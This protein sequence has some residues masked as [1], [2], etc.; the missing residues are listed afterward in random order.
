MGV[1]LCVVLVQTSPPLEC[2]T[3]RV[4]GNEEGLR[5]I[6]GFFEGFWSDSTTVAALA[7][8]HDFLHCNEESCSH[9]GAQYYTWGPSQTATGFH[10]SKGHTRKT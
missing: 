1:P 2:V 8:P 4:P 9:C 3:K 6:G 7:T 5:L 10:T